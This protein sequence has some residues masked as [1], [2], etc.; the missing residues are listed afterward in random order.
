M[1]LDSFLDGVRRTV[2]PNGLTLIT[3]EHRLGGVV[4]I[5]TWVK[6]GYF[7]EPDEVAGMAHLFEHMFFKGSARFPGSEEIAQHVSALGG[8]TNAGTIYDSTNYYF[9]LPS[10]GFHR[11]VEIQADAVIN[12]LFDPAELRKEAEV[13]IEESNRK[14]DSPAAVATEMMYATA[15]TEHRMKRWR[16]GSNDVLRNI[17]RDDLIVFFQSLYRPANIIVAIAGDVS[18]E[19]ALQAVQASFGLLEPGELRKERGPSE[20]AQT[21]FRF[22]ESRG[23]I[24]QSYS[25]LGWHTPGEHYPDEEALDLLSSVLGS[26][27]YSR[28]YRNVVG[29]QKASSASAS[30]T[31]FEDAG[32]FTVRTSSEDADLENVEA[33][34][35]GEVVRMKEYGPTAFELELAKNTMEA[36]LVLDLEDVLGQAQ[37][38]AFFES[39]GSFTDIRTHLERLRAVSADDVRRAAGRY[40][41]H[42]NLT[43]YRYRP[44]GTIQAVPGAVERSLLEI[45][46]VS[47]PAPEEVP[48]PPEAG[49]PAE[50]TAMA[51]LHSS[52]LSNGIGLLVR[53]A[54]GTPSVSMAVYFRGGR[55]QE[56]LSNAGITQLMARAMRRGTAT[57]SGEQLDREIEFYGTQIGISV[58]DD[59]FGFAMHIVS[60][61]FREGATL[62]ADL[63]LNPVFPQKGIE[64]DRHL[65]LASIRRALDSSSERPFQL[66][67][68]AF[69]GEH[70]YGLPDSGFE[71]SVK[72]IDG[73]QLRSWYRKQ[74]VADGCLIVITGDVATNAARELAE[75]LFGS[76]QKSEGLPPAV[77]AAMGPSQR[78]DVVE[79]RDRKQTAIVVGFPAVPPQHADWTLL[80]LLQ[81]VTSGLA[82]TF[83][84]E[85]RGRRAL[86]YTVYAGTQS[87]QLGGAFVGYIASEASKEEEAREGLIAEIHRLHLDGISEENLR[88]AQS[89]LSG[90]MKI[91]LQTNAAFAA[92][93]AQNYL[94]ALGLDFTER[95]LERI[96]AVTLDEIRGVAKK[97]LS[98]ENYVVATL[99]GRG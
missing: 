61:N 29:P 55:L 73:D 43:L 63:V 12:P 66:F 11:A 99:R 65:Q 18:H 87:H 92:E 7:H 15:F 62:L 58:Q 25:V 10:E 45:H 53:E 30:N 1:I 89:H 4:A 97:Y 74:V 50:A 36:G 91:R 59:F 8:S 80:R 49:P 37:T 85:L 95:F 54:A 20:P 22:A 31:V 9:L 84:A 98:G 93:L 48:L 81:D 44:E 13:V 5:N 75:S 64:D 52:V 57:R 17:R 35:L 39:R 72:S 24:K 90:V 14:F 51:A 16:I 56:S 6:A 26:G 88:R 60:R 69:Y 71:S 38:L 42:S 67:A 47:A 78:I 28:F 34:I 77:G 86:A 82:G 19:E 46:Q 79:E 21:E 3:R 94:Y 83:F 2:L 33:L 27:R 76:L 41:N 70:P 40:L 23:D 96:R 32:I 68:S